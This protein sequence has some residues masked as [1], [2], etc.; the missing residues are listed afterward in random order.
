LIEQGK[1]SSGGVEAGKVRAYYI[2]DVP[3]SHLWLSYQDSHFQIQERTTD[4]LYQKHSEDKFDWY[5]YIDLPWPISDRHWIV[6]VWN[7]MI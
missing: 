7:S 5:G 3:K 1:T 2:A 6:K 4:Y